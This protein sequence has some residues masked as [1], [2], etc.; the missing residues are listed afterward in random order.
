[1][2]TYMHSTHTTVLTERLSKW[3]L[4]RK[5]HLGH[6]WDSLYAP[7]SRIKLQ[8]LSFGGLLPL[9]W[10]AASYHGVGVKAFFIFSEILEAKEGL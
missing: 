6:C 9:N 1:M 2:Y 3:S 5:G 10:R 8:F 4:C 7:L